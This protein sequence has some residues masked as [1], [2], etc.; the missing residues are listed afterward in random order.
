VKQNYQHNLEGHILISA[1]V[2]V[3]TELGK[4]KEC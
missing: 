4:G 1:A 2:P 3:Q